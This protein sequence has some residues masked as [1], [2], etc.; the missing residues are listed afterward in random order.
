MGLSPIGKSASIA[1][2]ALSSSSSCRLSGKAMARTGLR[3]MPTFPSP[4]LK[5]RTAGFP[6]YGFKAGISDEAFPTHR[7]AIVLRA[8]CFHR[9]S[10]LCV[11]ARRACE[12]LHAS[13]LPLYP[14]GPRS[15]PGYSVPVHPRLCDP[16][17]PTPGHILISPPCGLYRMPSLCVS[18]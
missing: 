7:F 5:F 3:M 6:Q 10:L 9:G 17:R 4:P 18:A 2:Q 8:L 13:G 1:A 15:S 12:H 14:R 16:I 11:R